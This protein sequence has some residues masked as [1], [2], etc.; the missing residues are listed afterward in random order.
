MVTNRDNRISATLALAPGGGVSNLNDSGLLEG[1]IRNKIQEFWDHE[2][3][4]LY[5]V[6]EDDHFVPIEAAKDL[7]SRSPEPKQMVVLNNADHYHFCDEF[8][9]A[10]E[11]FRT[12]AITMGEDNPEAKALA[13]MRPASELLPSSK[14]FEYTCG[15]GLAHMDSYLKDKIEA[16]EFLKSDLKALLAEREIEVSVY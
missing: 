15:L 3:G 14:A 1:E 4:V 10:H 7:Y 5:L 8:E 13:S 12:E 9:R 2:V 11:F 16:K 6:A